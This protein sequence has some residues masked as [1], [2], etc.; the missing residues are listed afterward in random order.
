MTQQEWFFTV[1]S[2]PYGTE[3][4]GGYQSEQ[5]AMQGIERIK[6]KVRELNDG[7]ERTYTA[8]EINYAEAL[9]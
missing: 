2:E 5:D 3:I 4:Y 9:R 6:S 7:I 1:T 8:P